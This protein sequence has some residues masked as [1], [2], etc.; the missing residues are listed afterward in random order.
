[1]RGDTDLALIQ[2]ALTLEKMRY[3]N[4]KKMAKKVFNITG[5]EILIKLA[6]V[7]KKHYKI[8]KKQIKSIK[9]FSKAN[10]NILRSSEIKLLKEDRNFR[11][12]ISYMS[13]DIDIIKEAE[14]LERKDPLFYESISRKTKNGS[15]RK[16]FQF[17]KKEENKHLN[18][19]KSKRRELQIL[20]SRL[21]L[22]KDPR[23]MFYNM[24]SRG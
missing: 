24:I 6:G 22:A 4:Y 8:L 12:V 15:L 19:L 20:S 7:E 23:V 18:I 14:K 9:K 1:M 11:R 13:H 21:S 5:K 17:L 16:V 3:E 10:L 2:K